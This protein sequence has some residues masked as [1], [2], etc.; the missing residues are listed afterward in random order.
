M[1]MHLAHPSLTTTGRKK[2]KQK[3][4]SAEQKRQ[5][6]A[7]EESWNQKMQEYKAMSKSSI[8]K[9]KPRSAEALI[10]KIPPGRASSRHIPSIDSGHRGAVASPQSPQYTGDA[11]VGIAVM[12]KS[13]LQPVFSQEAAIDSEI[14]RAHV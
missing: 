1:T 3:W 11:V 7:M 2:Q 12:H 13:C 9:P 10:P 14:G 6:I 4:A 8:Y 5:H